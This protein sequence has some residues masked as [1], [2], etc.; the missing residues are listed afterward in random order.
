VSRTVI[1]GGGV[2]GLSLA[3]ELACRSERSGND[4][5]IVLIDSQS[6]AARASWSGAGILLPAN[7]QTAIHPIDQLEG[8]SNQRHEAWSKQLKVET[9][10]DNGFRKCGGLY[11]ARTVGEIALLSGTLEHWRL[12]EID[13]E[14]LTHDQLLERFSAFEPMVKKADRMKSV[15][16]PSEYQFRNPDHLKALIAACEK[17]GVK[18]HEHV[19]VTELETENGSVTAIKSE[20][21]TWTGDQFCLTA[22]PWTSQLCNSIGFE[23]PMQPVKGHVVL[24]KLDQQMFVPVINEGSRYLVPRDDGHVLA[25]STIQETDF[26]D[27][28]D[29]NEIEGLKAWASSVLPALDESTFV[30]GWT[31]LRPGTFDGFPYMGPIPGMQNAFVSTGHFKAGLQLSPGCAVAMAD[32]MT[33][34]KPIVDMTPFAVS[35]AN[36]AF[37]SKSTVN[38]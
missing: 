14:P 22:G 26:D 28:I 34:T 11:V 30:N 35:R 18:F 13:F 31:G 17:R 15:F 20:S 24:Y 21:Q 12:R 36:D 38:K 37:Y 16:V 4:R 9:G 3:W 25:G 33:G 6:L 32:L 7:A 23:L 8:I 1:V 27:S 29:P 2:I 19:G 5:E 10:I